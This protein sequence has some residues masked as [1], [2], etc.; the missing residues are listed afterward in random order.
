MVKVLGRINSINVQKVMWCTAELGLAVD[1]HDIGMEFGG[2]DTPE[3]LAKNP[4]GLIPTLQDGDLT[5]W[6]SN[7]I[8]RYLTEAYGTGPWALA[9]PGERALASQWMD[10]YLTTMH[11]PLSNVFRTL[12]RTPET[13]RDMTAVEKAAQATNRLWLMLEAHLEGRDFVLGGSISIGDIPVGCA[14][15]RWFNMDVERPELP[16]VTAWYERLQARKPYQDH[17]MMPLT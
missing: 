17:V 11:A 13:E 14:V 16:N 7:T 15:Y 6:E 9:T 2:N 8:V 4:N 10:W 1:R 5:V 3:Y 12:I